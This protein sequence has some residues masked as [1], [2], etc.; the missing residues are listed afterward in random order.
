MKKHLLL[1]LPYLLLTGCNAFLDS[2]AAD[3]TLN[4]VGVYEGNLSAEGVITN[5]DMIE[6]LKVKDD[7]IKI[8]PYNETDASSFNA[9]VTRTEDDEYFLTIE[10]QEIDGIL[11]EGRSL[12]SNDP[13]THGRFDL[14]TKKLNYWLILTNEEDEV[15]EEVFTGWKIEE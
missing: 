4:L 15:F 2:I 7:E 3:K 6:V 11:I 10:P 9:K 5:N 13:D 8:V 12:S 1:L 14:E